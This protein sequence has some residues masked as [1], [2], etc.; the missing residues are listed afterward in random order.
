MNITEWLSRRN[1]I[2]FLISGLFLV[3]VLGI[4]DKI[5]G[6]EISFSIFYL[7]PV[8]FVTRFSDRWVGIFISGASAI[9]WLMAD[10]MAGQIYSHWVI[11]YWNA[12]M[13]FGFFLVNVYILSRLK[14]ALEME[15]MLSRMDSLTGIANGKYFIEL[16]NSEFIRS[17]TNNLSFTIAYMDLDNIKTVN[18]R[19]GHN[20]GDIV[21]CT[22]ASIIRN[23]IRATD[24]VGRLGGDEFAILFPEMGA[25]ESQG[26]IPKIHKSLLDAILENKWGITISMGV[27]TFKGS[28]FNAEEIL[29][30][31]ESLMYSVKDAGKNGIKY[32]VFGN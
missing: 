23:N 25:E 14:D 8:I 30:L 18:D 22:M 27:G 31:T 13:R 19:F 2:F 1:A 20:E 15:K 17:N 16:V 7:I 28:N 10:L 3:V 9:A 21:L 5:T 26:I 6:S 32:E 29:R 11:P 4:I 24:S 12:I